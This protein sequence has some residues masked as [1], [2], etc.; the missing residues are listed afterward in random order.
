MIT[1]PVGRYTVFGW[2]VFDFANSA[3]TTLVVT[4]VYS[5]YFVSTIAPD[6]VTGTALWSRGVTLTGV[7]VDRAN[8]ATGAA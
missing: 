1:K 7:P 8:A 2:V 6:P 4:F 3:Y 5:T